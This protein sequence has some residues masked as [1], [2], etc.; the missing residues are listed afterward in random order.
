MA[1]HHT[2]SG[3]IG[4]LVTESEV[5]CDAEKYYKIIK[6]HE[7]VPNATPYVS[8][9]KVTEGH[10]TTS[11]CVK[12]WNFVVAGRNEYVLE[13]TTYNDETRTICH[14]DFEGDL[15]KKYK[16]FDAILVVKPKDNGHGSNVRWTIEY[17]KNN[18]DSP[19]PI[20]YLGFFQ[21]LIDDLNSHL[22]SS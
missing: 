7:D 19:V 8:D 4:K 16:K 18:E 1:Q 22:C 17:E 12:Q 3:L 14:S 11:G 6:H 10:G 2:I 15:M 9:V 5:N 20:D 21:S 13:K